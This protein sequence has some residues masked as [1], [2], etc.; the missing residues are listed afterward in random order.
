MVLVDTS[1][2]IDA[3]NGNK[4]WQV[5]TLSDLLGKKR[6]ILGDIILTEILEGIRND[7]DFEKTK[8]ILNKFPC[9]NLLG[10][11]IAIKAARNYRLLR[12]KGITIRKTIDVIIGTFCIAEKI[13]L[14]HDDKDFDPMVEHLGLK[15]IF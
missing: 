7:N 1:V 12:K 6:V 5:E 8:T 14:L 4:T 13:P 11:E 2:W 10:K 15:T 9:L 3:F